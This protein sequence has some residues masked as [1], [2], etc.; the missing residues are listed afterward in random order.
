M[1]LLVDG[2]S[3]RLVSNESADILRMLDACCEVGRTLRPKALAREI[4]LWNRIVHR[5]VDEGVYRAGFAESQAACETAVLG[6]FG[7]LER[8]EARLGRSRWLAGDA[9]TEADLRLFPTLARF[10]AAY[11]TAFR[12]NWKRLTEFPNLRAYAREI[13]AMPGV[14]ETVAFDAYR[15]GC[16][17]PSETRNPLGIVPIGPAPADWTAPHGRG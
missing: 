16:N 14:A 5:D 7:A 15:R 9:F 12:C 4:D 13:Y 8:I 1:P 6:I 10:D 2:A 11:Y 17:S 3:G